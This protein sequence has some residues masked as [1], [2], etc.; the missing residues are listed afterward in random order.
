MQNLTRRAFVGSALIGAFTSRPSAAAEY[1]FIQY[2]NQ[3]AA[4]PLH[5]RLVEM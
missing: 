4:S 5:R 2:H 3:T 1:S